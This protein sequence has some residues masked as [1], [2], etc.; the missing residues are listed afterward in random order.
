LFAFDISR[1]YYLPANNSTPLFAPNGAPG[2][3]PRFDLM[4][5]AVVVAGPLLTVDTVM[6]L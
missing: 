4:S 5:D 2:A 1:S 6:L 3:K